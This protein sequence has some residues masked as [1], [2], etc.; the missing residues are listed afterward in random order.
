[1]ARLTCL[2]IVLISLAPTSLAVAQD[3]PSGQWAAGEALLQTGKAAYDAG[4]YP[5]ALQDFEQALAR[6][7]RPTIHYDIGQAAARAG[8]HKRALVAFREYLSALPNAPNRPE[9]ERRIQLHEQAIASGGVL[10]SDLSPSAA[11]NAQADATAHDSGA[12]TTTS[13]ESGGEELWW[14][15]AGIGAAVVGMVVAALV[16]NAS[17]DP[18][19]PPMRG[20]VGGTIQTLEVR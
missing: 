15:W 9:V 19:Q 2:A 12:L 6:L 16:V 4:N 3:T 7:G 20:D 14:L 10:P 11:A 5:Q 18:V 13:N 1:M 17:D 8:D